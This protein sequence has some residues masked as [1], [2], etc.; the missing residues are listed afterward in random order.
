MA[1]ENLHIERAHPMAVP[2]RQADLLARL[3]QALSEEG[4]APPSDCAG[5]CVWMGAVFC[6]AIL[7]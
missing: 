6:I 1:H 2:H 5:A 3:K 4:V 7:A